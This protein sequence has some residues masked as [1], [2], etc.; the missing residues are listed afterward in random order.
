MV[1]PMRLITMVLAVLTLCECAPRRKQAA[2]VNK[3]TAYGFGQVA[4]CITANATADNECEEGTTANTAQCAEVTTAAAGHHGYRHHRHRHRRHRRHRHRR[5]RHCRRH[6]HRHRHC[7][8]RHRH[9]HRYRY[10]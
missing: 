1:R 9:R 2:P 10:R 3:I 7:R 5:R 6:R 8:H 4:N